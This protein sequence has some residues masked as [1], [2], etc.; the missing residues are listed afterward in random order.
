MKLNSKL[1]FLS[2]NQMSIEDYLT[3]LLF[4]YIFMILSFIFFYL[5]KKL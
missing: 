4:F 1:N 5:T 3:S 2:E